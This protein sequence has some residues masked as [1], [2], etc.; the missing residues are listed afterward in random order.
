MAGGIRA[1]VGVNE[2]KHIYI[3]VYIGRLFKKKRFI[4]KQ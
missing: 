2:I 1:R 3:Y 4:K